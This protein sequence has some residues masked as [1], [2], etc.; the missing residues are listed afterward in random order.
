MDEGKIVEIG[1]PNEFFDNPKT[2]RAANFIS[3]ILTH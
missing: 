2:D 1:T 3:M